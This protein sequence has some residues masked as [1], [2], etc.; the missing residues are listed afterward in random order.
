MKNVNAEV[1]PPEVVPASKRNPPIGKLLWTSGGLVL[2]VHLTPKTR[3]LITMRI[4]RAIKVNHL[5]M[6]LKVAGWA[7]S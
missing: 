3:L 1:Q 7:T 5:L 6:R 2:V 4:L